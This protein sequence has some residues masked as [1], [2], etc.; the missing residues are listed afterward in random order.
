MVRFYLMIGLADN[1]GNVITCR[2]GADTRLR[3]FQ[4][5]TKTNFTTVSLSASI[6]TSPQLNLDFSLTPRTTTTLL[7][8]AEINQRKENEVLH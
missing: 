2:F 3:N 7:E 4:H 1:G 8:P 6:S 5:T